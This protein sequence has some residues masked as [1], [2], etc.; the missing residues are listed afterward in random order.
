MTHWSSFVEFVGD[1][2]SKNIF[3]VAKVNNQAM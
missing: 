3:L 1:L 2:E